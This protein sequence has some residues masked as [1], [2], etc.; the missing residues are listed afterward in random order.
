MNTFTRAASLTR[1]DTVARECGLDPARL[2]LE[3]GLDACIPADP[4]TRLPAARFAA[5]LELAAVRSRTENFGLR[6]AQH[7]RLSNLGPVGMLVRDQ[8]TLGDALQ[9]LASQYPRLNNA[10]VARLD[11]GDDIV[12]VRLDLILGCPQPVRQAIEMVTSVLLGVVRGPMG[13][14]WQPRMVHFMHAPPRD[15]SLHLSVFG[16]KLAFDQEFN[17]LAINRSDLATSNPAADPAAARYAEQL[18]ERLLYKYPPQAVTDAVRHLVVGLLP[19]G[20]CTI[21]QVA[22]PLGMTP[23]T[24]QRKLAEQGAVFSDLV[25]A[26]RLE[27][28]ERCLVEARCPLTDL[29]Q[30]L[31]FTSGSAF[32]RWYMAHTGTS[33][34]KRRQ[35]AGHS[36]GDPPLPLTL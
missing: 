8:P 7:R 18:I 10:L 2:L 17:G 34:S 33:P 31:G 12:V 25:D 20:L 32:S 11:W 35:A 28:A 14:L 15:R 36:L 1:F 22:D 26:V 23:R 29:A 13:P 21:D 27:L 30:R 4:D 19:Q 9:A 16:S 6:M 3:V 24:L 5:L